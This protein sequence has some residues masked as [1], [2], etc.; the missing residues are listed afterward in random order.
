MEITHNDLRIGMRERISPQ[1]PCFERTTI[2]L[3]FFHSLQTVYADCF[4]IKIRG[5]APKAKET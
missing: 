3:L 2:Y 1:F 5:F 4:H